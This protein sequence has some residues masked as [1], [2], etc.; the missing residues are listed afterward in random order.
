MYS[1]SVFISIWC[2]DLFKFPEE[3]SFTMNG[4]G[5][6]LTITNRYT[7]QTEEHGTIFLSFL[8]EEDYYNHYRRTNVSVQEHWSLVPLFLFIFPTFWPSGSGTNKY[9]MVWTREGPIWKM[10]K[11]RSHKKFSLLILVQIFPN[12]AHPMYL[13]RVHH[14]W[15]MYWYNDCI[16]SKPK[17]ASIITWK[18]T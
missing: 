10:L 11:Q 15:Q 6:L 18:N 12:R 16:L 13:F 7:M 2:I 14:N 3:W 17:M 1:F 4:C 9:V 8:F 5:C